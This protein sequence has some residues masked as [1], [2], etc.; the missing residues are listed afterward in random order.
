[1]SIIQDK[2]SEL[3]YLKRKNLE[4]ESRVVGN[5]IRDIIHSYGI[6]CNFFKLKSN[7]SEE[8]DEEINSTSLNIEA[9]G[10]DPNP[11]YLIS[12]PMITYM[13]V[14]N[15][16]FNLN[17]YGIIPNADVNF[18]FDRVDFA[19]R[20]ATKLGKLKEFA[21]QPIHLSI[22]FESEK[23]YDNLDFDIPIRSDVLTGTV[24]LDFNPNDL[25]FYLDSDT[26][27][28]AVI[29]CEPTSYSQIK[30]EFPTNP[31]LYK[32]FNYS[33]QNE[34][35]IYNGL[36]DIK[37][38]FKF[39]IKYKNKYGPTIHSFEELLAAWEKYADINRGDLKNE[40]NKIPVKNIV[41]ASNVNFKTDF[42]LK[43]TKVKELFNW[44]SNQGKFYIDG[45]IVGSI[46]YHDL[47]S[48][49]KYASAL[50]PMVG[51]IITI[52]FPNE[53]NSEQYEIT[54]C[55]DKDLSENGINPLMHKYIWKCKARRYVN[56]QEYFPAENDANLKL[57][58]KLDLIND[59]AIDFAE[60]IEVYE[61]IGQNTSTTI[62][63]DAVYGGYGSTTEFKDLTSAEDGVD[64]NVITVNAGDVINP[65]EILTFAEGPRLV[66][67]GYDLYFQRA[68]R[69]G[70]TYDK[71]LFKLNNNNEV[72]DGSDITKFV[73]L[74][75]DVR[76]IK[77]TDDVI[78]FVNVD[79]KIYKISSERGKDNS[80]ISKEKLREEF[81]VQLDSL[82]TPGTYTH[83][84]EHIN[85]SKLDSFYKFSNCN[86][87]L[88]VEN[89]ALKYRL[90]SEK[91]DN[92]LVPSSLEKIIRK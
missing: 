11:D 86:S 70:L 16:I 77:A 39:N 61:P 71:K 73:K 89:G 23:D 6:D 17:K 25:E 1:M 43:H 24:H 50:Q 8:F 74:N 27:G 85:T 13:E 76:F 35:N 2:L 55:T 82:E 29:V 65:I 7:Y 69:S 92:I 19:T 47:E 9:Y 21:I 54:D 53:A 58:E 4:E 87:L 91:T 14:E 59:A 80:E 46:L 83:G 5:Y 62:F 12:S 75:N 26:A 88:F 34:L 67:D 32:S 57:N 51:D 37:V 52:D 20:F 81:G 56:S 41:T 31:D 78:V 36:E 38:V 66:T 3:R 49:S 18:Y 44:F 63:E 90:G 30:L 15:D 72:T 45:V 79:N 22:E 28:A 10:Y 60:K 64:Y 42:K 48:V 68:D 33:T 40:K 84:V